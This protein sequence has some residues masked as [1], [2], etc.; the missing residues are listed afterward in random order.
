MFTD[1]DI[2][3]SIHGLQLA[4]LL[5][6]RFPDLPII[7]TVGVVWHLIGFFLTLCDSSALSN[8]VAMGGHAKEIKMVTRPRGEDSGCHAHC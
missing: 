1:V 6:D 2:P 5:R 8:D 7:I 3:G 4:A